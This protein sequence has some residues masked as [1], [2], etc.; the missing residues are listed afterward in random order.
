MSEPIKSGDELLDAIEE[1][2]VSVGRTHPKGMGLG[3][4]FDEIT[5]IDNIIRAAIETGDFDEGQ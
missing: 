5:L 2:A 3:F 1:L 4:T